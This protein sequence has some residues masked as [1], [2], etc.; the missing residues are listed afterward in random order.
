MKTSALL[1]II[2]L[3][4]CFN[5]CSEDPIYNGLLISTVFSLQYFNNNDENILH[6]DSQIEVYYDKD[7]AAI[8][9][10]KPNLEYPYG[11]RLSNLAKINQ[12]DST[13]L[14]IEVFASDFYYD[15]NLS[16]TFIKLDNY[17]SDTVT[18]EFHRTLNITAIQKIWC[19]NELIFDNQNNI[20][21]RY[22]TI[23]IIK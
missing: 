18:C 17:K 20:G 9:F 13:E 23:R 4:V 11:Y 19:N 3:S 1:T 8:K 14:C 15:K 22:Q 7:G 10:N 6:K 5:S 12:G 21:T 16:T 2:L